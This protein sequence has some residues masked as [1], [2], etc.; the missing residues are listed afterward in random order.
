MRRRRRKEDNSADKHNFVG[1]CT[2][3]EKPD[4]PSP[5]KSPGAKLKGQRYTKVKQTENTPSPRPNPLENPDFKHK[6]GQLLFLEAVAMGLVK[7]EIKEKEAKALTWLAQTA[8]GI[9][10]DSDERIKEDY[11]SEEWE[12]K[13]EAERKAREENRRLFPSLQI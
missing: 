9:L 1:N 5:P 11:S 8:S 7:E 6:R 2:N 13:L 3:E 12:E 10:K 4:P